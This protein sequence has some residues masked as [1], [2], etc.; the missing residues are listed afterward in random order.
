MGGG[1]SGGA[2]IAWDTALWCL[3]Q[4]R[5]PCC[6]CCG[7]S[8][9]EWPIKSSTNSLAVTAELP[10]LFAQPSVGC[11][12]GCGQ[13]F[14]LGVC[15][16]YSRCLTPAA[17]Q[18]KPPW[19]SCTGA[20]FAC[21]LLAFKQHIAGHL[22]GRASPAGCGPLLSTACFTCVCRK[23]TFLVMLCHGG[24]C[25]PQMVPCTA[26]AEMHFTSVFLRNNHGRL[27]A[28]AVLM[29]VSRFLLR[30][31]ASVGTCFLTPK[32]SPLRG[33]GAAMRLRERNHGPTRNS[34]MTASTP[35][36]A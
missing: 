15:E 27:N 13:R 10:A 32:P 36:P 5:P 4:A 34:C 26:Q 30:Q 3:L 24:T 20:G 2:R 1:S 8:T 31:R 14:F 21:R 17:K 16:T 22:E 35:Q 18:A 11:S 7:H 9:V 33:L 25:L 28:C 6:G 19:H 12:V 29:S 23:R